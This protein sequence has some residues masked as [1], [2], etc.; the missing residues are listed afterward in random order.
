MRGAFEAPA[1]A[2]ASGVC[3]LMIQFVG[4]D[5]A[6]MIDLMAMFWLIAIRIQS[7][8]DIETF[9]TSLQIQIHTHDK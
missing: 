9:C 1:I 6:V 2:G 4:A 8:A 7:A 5:S 3:K